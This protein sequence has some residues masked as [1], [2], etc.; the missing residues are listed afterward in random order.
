MCTANSQRIRG[1]DNRI[2]VWPVT[3]HFQRRLLS[4]FNGFFDHF[5]SADI[6]QCTRF[7]TIQKTCKFVFV[8]S[9]LVFVNHADSSPTVCKQ[10]MY[11][12]IH[13]RSL[14]QNNLADIWQTEIPIDRNKRH[15]RISS[16]QQRSAE[17]VFKN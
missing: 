15:T 13:C 11:R 8:R 4:A 10:I 16:L 5:D 7:H 9:R 2:G 3:E 1:I 17:L 6:I 12:V 14:I